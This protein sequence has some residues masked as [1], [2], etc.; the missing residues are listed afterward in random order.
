[1]LRKYMLIFLLLAIAL[2]DG[3]CDETQCTNDMSQN[4]TYNV[5]KMDSGRV[6]HVRCGD[7]IHVELEIL[8]GAGYYWYVD[9]LNTEYVELLPGADS[10]VHGEN[11]GGPVK[12]VWVFRTKNKGIAEIRM[13]HY[14]IWESKEKAIGHFSV[15]LSIE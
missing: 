15:T 9:N 3:F 11:I 7:V 13:D 1:M 14:R 6:L 10:Q 2:T 5:G 4:N 12:G 8:G